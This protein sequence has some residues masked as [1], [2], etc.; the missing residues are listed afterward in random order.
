LGFRSETTVDGDSI[1]VAKAVTA[2]LEV[3]NLPGWLWRRA[4]HQGFQAMHSLGDNRG[5]YL[6]ADLRKR[7]LEYRKTL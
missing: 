1:G 4:I 5:G 7:T 3:R 6:V 2:N